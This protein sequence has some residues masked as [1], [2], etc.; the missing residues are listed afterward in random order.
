LL[1]IH[2]KSKLKSS[3]MANF[4]KTQMDKI[5]YIIKSAKKNQ[6]T[7]LVEVVG[8]KRALAAAGLPTELYPAMPAQSRW[9]KVVSLSEA[10]SMLEK[11][12]VK[13]YT[14]SDGTKVKGHYRD[15]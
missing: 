8:K 4:S 6:D 10:K 9:G 2:S 5:R 14:K 15:I 11:T 3:D 7:I 13:G 1:I 12:W